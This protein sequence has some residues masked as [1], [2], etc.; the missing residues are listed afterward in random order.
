MTRTRLL[1]IFLLLTVAV[2][3][4]GSQGV[5]RNGNPIP[6]RSPVLLLSGYKLD[7]RWAIDSDWRV[8][9]KK[10]GLVMDFSQGGYFEDATLTTKK[11]QILWA[12]EQVINKH[13]AR[14]VYTKSGQLIASFPELN[15]RFGAQLH[16]QRELADMLLMIATFDEDW[17]PVGATSI[18]ALPKPQK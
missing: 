5:D 16:N 8:I 17:Y 2:S 10:N 4:A 3:Q 15:A 12:Q 14:F 11:E 7:I 9:W 13:K 18:A 1:S 6:P